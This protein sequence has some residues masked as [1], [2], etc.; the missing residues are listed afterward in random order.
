MT[1]IIAGHFRQ[2]KT[3]ELI[4]C[5]YTWP[6]LYTDVKNFCNS[7]VTCM[8]SKLQ[9]YK[10][11]RMLKQLLIPKQPWNLISIDFIEKLPFSF[12]YNII[13]VII[14]QLSKQAIFVLI[15]D[16]II[17]HKLAKLFIIHVFFKY[18]ISSHITS[19]C[20]TKFVSNFFRSLEKSLDMRLHFTSR[21][22]TEGDNQTECTN[23]MLK[24]Y[25]YIYYNYQ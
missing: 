25:L 4:C 21:Y 15:A 3:L 24:K 5:D 8:R 22:Y 9:H 23:Q 1:S 13:L 12:S 11:Y 16:T 2:D 19:D 14:D 7:C 18:R 6:F 20:R 10:L 17:L